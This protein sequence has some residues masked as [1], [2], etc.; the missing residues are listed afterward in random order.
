V[1]VG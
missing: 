1:K